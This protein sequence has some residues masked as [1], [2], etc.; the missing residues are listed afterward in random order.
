MMKRVRVTGVAQAHIDALTDGLQAEVVIVIDNLGQPKN[1][2]AYGYPRKSAPL[3]T[4]F[5][6]RALYV[7]KARIWLVFRVTHTDIVVHGVRKG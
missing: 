7:E 2:D 1:L 4:L 6:E 5:G 3:G